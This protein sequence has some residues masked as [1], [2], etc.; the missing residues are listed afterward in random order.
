[1]NSL[2]NT[3]NNFILHV[4]EIISSNELNNNIINI[5]DIILNLH[6]NEK[7]NIIKNFNDSISS[8]T[9]FNY[10]LKKKIKLFSHKNNDTLNISESIFGSKL[11]LKKIFNNQEETIK[12]ALWKDLHNI[13]LNYNEYLLENNIYDSESSKSKILKKINK[14]NTCEI[15][16]NTCDNELNT[17]NNT[18]NTNNTQ[19]EQIKKNLNKMLNTENLNDTTNNMINDIFTSFQNPQN[20][21][22]NNNPFANIFELSKT[23]SEK[24]QDK[25]ETGEINLDDLL[26]NMSKLPGMESISSVVEKISSSVVEQSNTSEKVVID[27]NYSTANIDIGKNND[28]SLLSSINIGT[29]LKGMET[30]GINPLNGKKTNNSNNSIDM[31]SMMDLLHNNDGIKDMLNSLTSNNEIKNMINSLNNSDEIKTMFDDKS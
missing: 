25:I 1:M 18:N 14:L 12:L 9:N 27:E 20:T 8:E 17:N 21:Q 2:N 11:S 22:N 10:L 29:M 16:L 4:K 15:E 24:Y 30:M 7:L 26:K 6:E 28:N 5:T 23:I 13:L 19:Q 3:F 31:S